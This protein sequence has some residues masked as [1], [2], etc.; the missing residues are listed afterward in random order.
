MPKVDELIT[1]ISNGTLKLPE[2]QRG[3]I[4]TRDQVRTFVQ[5]LYRGHPTG[6]LLVWHA[7]GPVRTRGT[8][9]EA[10]GKTLLLLDGQQ[11]LTSL[12]A[13]IKGVP[14]PFY[15]GEHLFFNLYF[16]VVSEEF[17]YFSKSVMDGN[18]VWFSVHDFLKKG[19]NQ[20]LD[21]LP[22]LNPEQRDLAQKSLSKLN[23]LDKIHSYV[24]GV[25][26][27][28]DERLTLGDVVEIFNRVNSKGTPL[29]R[30][31]LAMAHICTFWPE[32]R[33]ELNTFNKKM[34]E[35]G[36][37]LELDLLVRATSAAAGGSVNFDAA[38][39]GLSS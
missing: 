1:D 30:S 15:E 39:Y 35:M 32:A 17:S 26:D 8:S 21:E 3:Y 6:H 11:R 2:F 38:F 33:G 12:F 19:M 7:V 16:N 5:S 29:K 28:K 27:L 24:Y 14:P 23:N 10:P 31:D 18:P 9:T 13:L 37:A 22:Q 25:D 36:F 20:F 4:W 34:G